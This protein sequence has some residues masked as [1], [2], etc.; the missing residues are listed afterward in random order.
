MPQANL[1]LGDAIPLGLVGGL[2]GEW[3]FGC[4]VGMRGADGADG[5]DG[6]DGTDRTDRADRSQRAGM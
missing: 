5:T 4:R 6:T 1:G 3:V 2:A